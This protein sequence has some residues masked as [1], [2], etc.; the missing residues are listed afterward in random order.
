VEV[1]ED[2]VL[3][4]DQYTGTVHRI[5]L[6]REKVIFRKTYFLRHQ[7]DVKQRLVQGHYTKPV[8]GMLCQFNRSWCFTSKFPFPHPRQIP[9]S[10]IKHKPHVCFRSRSC[11]C[12]VQDATP[13]HS[14]PINRY[15]CRSR[16]VERARVK[17]WDPSGYVGSA[18]SVTSDERAAKKPMLQRCRLSLWPVKWGHWRK[19]TLYVTLLQLLNCIRRW[20]RFST[21]L[22]GLG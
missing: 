8:F 11:K 20:D 7:G 19:Y 18:C 2:S 21:K 4:T 1:C 5:L 14:S 9:A 10:E 12:K 3:L 22:E 16:P 6:Y 13:T 17:S 15:R